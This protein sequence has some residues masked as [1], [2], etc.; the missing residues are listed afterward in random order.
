MLRFTN[1]QVFLWI[2][3]YP[4]ILTLINIF[5]M[6]QCQYGIG[7]GF[8]REART[9]GHDGRSPGI[10]AA[11]GG[12]AFL[13]FLAEDDALVVGSLGGGLEVAQGGVVGGGIAAVAHQV[14]G[15]DGD[16]GDGVVVG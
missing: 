16:G 13:F 3:I 8:F 14:A 11:V 9:T 5:R 2:Y 15:D 12:G 6:R 10:G 7:W 4:P 1:I